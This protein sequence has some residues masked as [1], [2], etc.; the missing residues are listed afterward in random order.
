MNSI[1]SSQPTRIFYIPS[2]YENHF[3]LV[4][5]RLMNHNKNT[6]FQ[7]FT[8]TNKY[9][10]KDFNLL[11]IMCRILVNEE[12]IQM[13]FTDSRI[14][15]L[16]VAKLCQEYPR[17]HKVGM[18]FLHTLQCLNRFLMLD[19]FG[20]NECIPTLL[21][22]TTVDWKA[23]LKTIEM[24]LSY[25]NSDGYMKSLYGVDDQLS[26]VRVSNFKKDL[27]TMNVYIEL[28]KEQHQTNLLPLFRVY[29]PIEKYSS[30]FLPSYIIQPFY[31]IVTY[32]HWRHV[33]ANACIFNKEIIMWP[34]VDAYS[35]W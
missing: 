12:N 16:V 4:F 20:I 33:I 35:G 7:I 2:Y 6:E 17:I 34:L 1:V 24:F 13:V 19:V 10:T 32:P 30:I 14:G 27:E 3:D 22:D 28:Y 25:H 9:T 11:L 5:D 21:V 23:N 8:L 15:Q 31:D 29:V 26:S 18:S